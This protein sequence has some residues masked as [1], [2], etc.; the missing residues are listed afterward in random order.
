MPD[1]T[2][3]WV[4]GLVTVV[5]SIYSFTAASSSALQWVHGLVTVVMF[6]A[7]LDPSVHGV[8]QWVHGL[9]TVV[10]CS[11]VPRGQ[12]CVASFNGSTVW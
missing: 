12:S 9:V 4:H 10:M 5:M 2:L 11:A 8:L 3:Q 1:R 7:A 6:R